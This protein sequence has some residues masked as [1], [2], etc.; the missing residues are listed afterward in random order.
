MY[1]QFALII[2][3]STRKAKL[4]VLFVSHVVKWQL[5]SKTLTGLTMHCAGN[6]T[7]GKTFWKAWREEC[8]YEYIV[9]GHGLK[10]KQK[11]V[12][13]NEDMYQDYKRETD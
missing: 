2:L 5:T 9:P 8:E 4:I 11:V 6:S 3:S 13:T 7:G 10:G 1:L 12:V